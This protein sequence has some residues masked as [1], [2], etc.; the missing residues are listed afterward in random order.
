MAFGQG[1]IGETHGDVRGRAAEGRVRLGGWSGH[2]PE[3]L[4][5]ERAAAL[6]HS[7]RVRI[8]K[9]L[10]PAI[11]ALVILGIVGATALQ[12]LV[13]GFDLGKIGLT[14][15]GN[16]VMTNPQ[17]SGHDGERSYQVSAA[18]A[19][20]N[21]FD[22]KVIRLEEI[23]ARI[24]LSADEWAAFTAVEGIYDSGAETLKLAD[25]IEIEYSRGYQA[26]LSGATIDLKNGAI[27]SDDAIDI[28]SRQGRFRAGKIDVSEDGQVL[29]FS[30]GISMVLKPAGLAG[31]E[32]GAGDAPARGAQ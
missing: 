9:R 13:S 8:M 2:T 24:K 6:R 16:I 7:R 19:V 27:L 30:N 10:L 18:R 21:L 29:R 11:S 14:G 20:Q 17:L 5:K 3:R 31:D 23:T 4:A 15:D 22:P 25:G 28:T 32:A 12:S 26:R 1:T